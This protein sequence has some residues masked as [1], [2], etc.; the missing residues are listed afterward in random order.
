MHLH[1][2]SCPGLSFSRSLHTSD[3]WWRFRKPFTS[4][5]IR[6]RQFRAPTALLTKPRPGLNIP[7]I[8]DISNLKVDLSDVPDGRYREVEVPYRVCC[9]GQQFYTAFIASL[10]A[11]QAVSYV[12]RRR[13]DQP[14]FDP[15]E[16][17][18]DGLPLVYNEQRISSFWKGK[19]GDICNM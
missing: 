6:S 18:E 8:G 13:L 9:S 10:S 3:S 7:G 5:H 19:P 17:D 4:C 11:L 2:S 12:S 15:Y 16:V 14:D 1:L